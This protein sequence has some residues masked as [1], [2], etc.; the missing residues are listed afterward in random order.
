MNKDKID[1]VAEAIW[2][3]PINKRIVDWSSI[4]EKVK[5]LWREDAKRAIDAMEN[6]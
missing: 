4:P 3:G 5:D 2:G 1:Q 6:Y